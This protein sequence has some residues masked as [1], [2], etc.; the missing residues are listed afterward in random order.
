MVQIENCLFREDSKSVGLATDSKTAL[1]G[2]GIASEEIIAVA[3]GVCS[4]QYASSVKA[5]IYCKKKQ[6]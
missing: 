3:S 2:I 5:N 1:S 6:G 4:A